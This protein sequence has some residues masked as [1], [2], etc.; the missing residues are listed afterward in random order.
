MVISPHDRAA[1][2]SHFFVFQS[3]CSMSFMCI[4]G[5]FSLG[6]SASGLDLRRC[7]ELRSSLWILATFEMFRRLDV[8]DRQACWDLG[9]D[10]RFGR[11]V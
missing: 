11:I 8:L 4:F 3:W 10:C 5:F 9:I 7:G 2:S 6:M 1:Q